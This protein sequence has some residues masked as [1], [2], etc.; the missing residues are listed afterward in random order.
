VGFM[1][2]LRLQEQLPLAIELMV[3]IEFAL[4]VALPVRAKA[5]TPPQARRA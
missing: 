4:F 5:V 1:L 2:V 3:V